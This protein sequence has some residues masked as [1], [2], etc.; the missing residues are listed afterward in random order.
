MKK[1][2]SKTILKKTNFSDF[3]IINLKSII[4]GNPTAGGG[5]ID[6]PTSG[7]DRRG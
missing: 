7:R 4:G 2:E 5:P 6:P 3:R 1:L